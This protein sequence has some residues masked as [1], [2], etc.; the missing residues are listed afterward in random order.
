MVSPF[1]KSNEAKAINSNS[2]AKVISPV[3]DVEEADPGLK[4]FDGDMIENIKRQM[5][6]YGHLRFGRNEPRIKMSDPDY[7]HLRFGK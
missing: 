2:L 3:Y 4:D 1:T 5:D 6:D 7:G